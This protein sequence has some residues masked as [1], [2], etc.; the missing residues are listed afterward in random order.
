MRPDRDDKLGMAIPGPGHGSVLLVED[1]VLIRLSLADHLRENGF[2]VLEAASAHEAQAIFLA[3]VQ[4]DA[5]F[6]DIHMPAPGDGIELALWI[7]AHF[8]LTPVLLASGVTE[9]LVAARIEAPHVVAFIDKPYEER[10][11][12]QCLRETLLLRMAKG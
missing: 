5:V 9:S 6:S 11:I 4:V 2:T 10:A 12:V 8:P 1:E 7:A 3:G